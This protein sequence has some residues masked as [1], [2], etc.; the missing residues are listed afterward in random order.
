MLGLV[1]ELNSKELAEK[2]VAQLRAERSRFQWVDSKGEAFVAGFMLALFLVALWYILFG[3]P[4]PD[5][6]PSIPK[7]Y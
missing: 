4:L 7:W 3:F 5:V 6:S 1:P 2:I